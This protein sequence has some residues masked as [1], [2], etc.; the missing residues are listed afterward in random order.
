MISC[1]VYFLKNSISEPKSNFLKRL[2]NLFGFSYYMFFTFPESLYRQLT[3]CIF[4]LIQS[5][6][7]TV[8]FADEGGHLIYSGSDD[9]FCKVIT[10][11][12]QSVLNL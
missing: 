12:T 6:V 4:F 3:R 2:L 1:C 9:N 10:Y 8:C 7:N 11:A 5:D